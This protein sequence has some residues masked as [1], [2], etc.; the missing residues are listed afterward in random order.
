MLFFV[1][2]VN[3]TWGEEFSFVVMSDIHYKGGTDRAKDEWPASY[4]WIFP[5]VL[6]EIAARKPKP[7]LLLVT[8]DMTE[9]YSGHSRECSPERYDKQFIN[10]REDLKRHLDPAITFCPMVGNHDYHRLVPENDWSNVVQ[11]GPD[12]YAQYIYP[13]IPKN[14]QPQNSAY[15]SFT[16]K[17][18]HMVIICTGLLGVK[19]AK[20]FEDL[21]Y[22]KQYE[23][24]AADL[25]K[26]AENP[27]VKNI[28]VFG[29]HNLFA[30]K[31]GVGGWD[32]LKIVQE[33]L[34]RGLFVQYGVEAYIHGHWHFYEQ[35]VQDS[36]PMLCFGGGS[37]LERSFDRQ[38]EFNHYA[39]IDVKDSGVHGRIYRMY[40][41]K[42]SVLVDTF[43]VLNRQAV[44][45]R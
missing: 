29:H 16:H 36:I 32:G 27:R 12:K 23:W 6:K 13:L 24:L 17:G 9:G 42:D 20:D 33:R 37:Q 31:G 38:G 21:V 45:M 28:F 44:R 1:T 41:K 18:T 10:L 25:K 34:W 7:D 30:M 19:K 43:D 3:V 11:S 14:A 35:N 40:E 4:S 22:G 2:I 15:Y 8:G 5:K 26:A 39:V